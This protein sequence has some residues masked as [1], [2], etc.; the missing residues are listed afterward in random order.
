MALD[1]AA[2]LEVLD[3]LKAGDA[4]ERVRVAAETMNESEVSRICADLDDQVAAFRSRTLTAASYPYVFLDATSCKLG[5]TTRSSPRPC[6]R[7]RRAR[8]RAPRIPGRGR[9]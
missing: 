9:G 1:H 4:G 2:L 5:S 6:R 8:R 3:T 7:D